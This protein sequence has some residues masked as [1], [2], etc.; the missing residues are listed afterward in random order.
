VVKKA[1]IF[2]ALDTTSLNDAIS[3]A[4]DVKDFVIGVKINPVFYSK[5]SLDKIKKFADMN[6]KIFSDNKIHDICS[7]VEKTIIGLNGQSIDYLTIHIANGLQTLSR[8]QNI[9]AGLSKPIKLLGV[10]VLTNFDD[11]TLNEIG[12]THK[13]EKQ[14]K[15][16][17]SLAQKAKLDGIVCDGKN[18]KNVKQVFKGEIF[19]PGVRLN[20]ET[21]HDQNISRCISPKE[22]LDDGASF[23]IC[24]REV[25]EGNVKGNIQ[26]IT[27]SLK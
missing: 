1:P 22:A 4:N 15:Q 2:V 27:N 24:G 11:S 13:M 26:K 18:I 23:C 8:A 21:I 16:L 17:A 10:T 14:I 6:L 12:I 25:T 9:A 3:I 20:K 5:N 19:V 7:T